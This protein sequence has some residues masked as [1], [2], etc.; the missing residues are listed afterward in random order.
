MK[1]FKKKKSV[2]LLT[3]FFIII[4]NTLSANA[5]TISEASATDIRLA[6]TDRLRRLCVLRSNY[7]DERGAVYSLMSLVNISMWFEFA[8]N[9]SDA[10]FS[11]AEMEPYYEYLQTGVI[12]FN[13]SYGTAN[14][15]LTLPINITS[16]EISGEGMGKYKAYSKE[17][18]Q[19]LVMHLG[20]YSDQIYLELI[21]G[22]NNVDTEEEKKAILD[23]SKASSLIKS[24]YEACMRITEEK[25]DIVSLCKTIDS[26]VEGYYVYSRNVSEPSNKIQQA[27]YSPL[28]LKAQELITK[29]I[30][31]NETLVGMEG[32]SAYDRYF[33]PIDGVDQVNSHYLK[34]FA[35]SA[36]YIP[37]QS[38]IGDPTFVSC[39]KELD[40][41]PQA[42]STYLS[43]YKRKKPLYFIKNSSKDGDG[44]FTEV[45]TRITVREF[46]DYIL[47]D[48]SGSLVAPKGSFQR[49]G[50][51]DSYVVMNNTG[52]K[53]RDDNGELLQETETET[54]EEGEETPSPEV[55][56]DP[57]S[58]GMEDDGD[59][60]L[61]GETLEDRT[62]MTSEVFSFGS[63]KPNETINKVQMFNLLK[64]DKSI[65][66]IDNLDKKLLYLD[67]FGNIVMDNGL[68]IIPA[69]ANACYYNRDTG[70]V[71]NPNTAMFMNYY[72]KVSLNSEY[73]SVSD[74]DEGKYIIG[75]RPSSGAK[76]VVN[77]IKSTLP[78]LST[79][80]G[81]GKE[82]SPEALFNQD[83]IGPLEETESS[84]TAYIIG[85]NK[86]SLQTSQIGDTSMPIEMEMFTNGSNKIQTIR[87][88]NFKYNSNN[89]IDNGVSSLR[90]TLSNTCLMVPDS[91]TLV[92]FG[93]GSSL[94]PLTGSSADSAYQ[95]K[96]K[97]IV[98]RFFD[99]M[100]NSDSGEYVGLN[101]RY[102]R[103]Y[104]TRIAQQGYNGTQ[105]IDTFS[106]NLLLEYVKLGITDNSSSTVIKWATK[107][108]DTAGQTAG[109]IGIKNAYEDPIFGKFLFYVE[110][111]IEIILV[112]V[113]IF[114]ISRF[115][116]KRVS[117]V[118]AIAG[119]L[120][121]VVATYTFLCVIP[122][123]M[124]VFLNGVL[125]NL[126]DDLAYSALYT[127]AEKYENPFVLGNSADQFSLGTTSL[128][129]Y[130]LRDD[131]I[132]ILCSQY[133]I[134]EIDIKSGTSYVID[135]DSGLFLE[136]DT[137]KMN[138]DRLFASYSI[139]GG[140][141]SES[142]SSIYQLSSTKYI[143]NCVDYYNPF[144]GIADNFIEKLNKFSSLYNIPPSQLQYPNKMYK[145]S[146]MVNCYVQSDLFLNGDDLSKLEEQFGT[147]LYVTAIGPNMFGKNNLDFLGL[148]KLLVKDV[149]S[150][151]N[152]IRDTLWFQTMVTN[153]YYDID[154]NIN[155]ED[156]MARLIEQ[157]N[158]ETK[159]FL[160]KNQS[161]MPYI[162]DENLIKSTALF[163]TTEFNRIISSATE[164]VYPQSLNYEELK[165]IDV[166]LPI[167]AKDYGKF[168]STNQDIV[169]LVDANFETVG[170]LVLII[171]IMEAW[172]LVK[173]MTFSV[174]ILYILLLCGI[175]VR[176]LGK[177]STEVSAVFSG[178]L[179]VFVTVFLS[180]LMFCIVTSVANRFSDS[181]WT[182][183]I[184]L[185]V[186]ALLLS[187][188]VTVLSTVFMSGFDLGSAKVSASL[189]DVAKTFKA[190]RAFDSIKQSIQRVTPWKNS[191]KNPVDY[192]RAPNNYK[193]Y[194]YD[195][196]LDDY[197]GDEL[198]ANVM[199]E[200]HSGFKSRY[201]EGTSQSARK[202]KRR[203]RSSKVSKEYDSVDE[204]SS[205][206]TVG[207]NFKDYK[208]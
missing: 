90:T 54:T 112:L 60:Y 29:D 22:Y 135:N 184:L 110:S 136:G 120:A 185:I 176:L 7:Q 64:D 107:V 177:A 155:D 42:I 96:S 36:S 73:F 18:T 121:S 53:V 114:F 69:A 150:N 58:I 4:F 173:I 61:I 151:I 113:V 192:D 10:K 170:L 66:S 190:D 186:Y 70:I 162:S 193:R 68:V 166:F 141:E 86:E 76:A 51:S 194:S 93:Y 140:Y 9:N 26:D 13:Q 77:S 12:K 45:G 169:S 41:D 40:S 174:P 201:G 198:Q 179:K 144:Y 17:L 171:I 191:D 38:V 159:Q 81:A 30:I 39:L 97:F 134:D 102:D 143:S 11:E 63:K 206:D 47:E 1:K 131:D 142:I 104:I 35:S 200:R 122:I 89:I 128:N 56:P 118:Y 78:I 205:D 25:D 203:Y 133:Q 146:F 43:V 207:D 48:S 106:K 130:K 199:E 100:S 103:L 23:D 6:T 115:L 175:L 164:C 178:Y 84:A 88:F 37:F 71:F 123:Y 98:K 108:V 32:S 138:V 49:N 109:V 91:S 31:E 44:Y 85:N 33:D 196:S 82:G 94:F 152:E 80:M 46:L 55:Q 5:V 117:F 197:Y 116:R 79:S 125:N 28:I 72:P 204:Y 20:T 181:L 187:V 34:V 124:P 8:A 180:F 95:S 59:T 148:Q 105:H 24:V 3:L 158:R 167:I 62:K 139:V 15:E 19:H 27:L 161:K 156:E 2:I 50:D 137:L 119:V 147:D 163:A 165:M 67:F 188:M 92:N 154:G 99:S 83:T 57:E 160:I 87:G 153:G 189:R 157:V 172:L 149:P 195:T 182:M 208:Y 126:S 168:L 129:L 75:M 21:T 74:R 183:F 16:P 52:L 111:F 132:D 127:K 101:N 202:N 145:D 14:E 65:E